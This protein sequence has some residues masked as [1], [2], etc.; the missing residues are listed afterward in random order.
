MLEDA[1]TGDSSRTWELHAQPQRLTSPG[2]RDRAQLFAA[3]TYPRV[4]E[5][6]GRNWTR[7]TNQVVTRVRDGGRVK[8]SDS[9]VWS[10]FFHVWTSA[11]G[12]ATRLS[13]HNDRN[14]ALKTAG[15][16]D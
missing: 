8:G 16:L 2:T 15:L 12:K 1:P 13:L 3:R 4:S 6:E 10:I 9:E 7:W 11:D 14:R 5:L